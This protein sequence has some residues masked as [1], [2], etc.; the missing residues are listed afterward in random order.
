MHVLLE[1]KLGALGIVL[2]D[3]LDHSLDDLSPS[4]AAVL[5]MLHFDPELTTTSLAAICGI[6]QPSAVRV[7]DG[8]C[9]LGLVERKPQRGR[10]TPLAVTTA[11]HR[12]AEA[13]HRSR[14][15][16]LH[17]LLAP[18]GAD[19]QQLLEALVDRVLAGAT[20][21]LGPARTTCRLCEHVLCAAD[22]CPVRGAVDR[23]DSAHVPRSNR[24][25]E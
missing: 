7:I 25:V 4:A 17:Q 15:Q 10:T 20:T 23:I 1:N 6:R 22:V 13:L 19:E 11:G 21:G 2:W 24:E 14:L 16:M 5:S 8:L 18:L 12:R 3:H 9:R